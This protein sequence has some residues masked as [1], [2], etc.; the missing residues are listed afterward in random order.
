MVM[1][2]SEPFLYLTPEQFGRFSLLEELHL[3]GNHFEAFPLPICQLCGLKKLYMNNCTLTK[4]PQQLNN[5]SCLAVVDFSYNNLGNPDSLPEEFF[6]LP[7]LKD[8][9][10]IDCQLKELPLAIGNLRS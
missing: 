2:R 3:A 10:L 1:Y 9:Y 6:N 5:M 8:L 4:I 7:N